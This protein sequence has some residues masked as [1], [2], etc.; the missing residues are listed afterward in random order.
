MNTP[1]RAGSWTCWLSLAALLGYAGLI[2][3][4]LGPA[5]PGAGGEWYTPTGFLYG[6]ET[7]QGTLESPPAAMG[8]AALPAAVL[9]AVVFAT[10]RSAIA[11]ALALSALVA[12][13]LFTF[14]GAQASF[15]WLFFKWR[16]SLVMIG[17]ALWVGCA[18]AAPFLAASWLRRGWPLRVALF[19]PVLFAALALMRNATGTDPD[20]P[21]MISPWPAIPVFGIVC[22]LSS[23]AVDRSP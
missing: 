14:Y 4:G 23:R 11:R 6:W 3:H 5:P 10:G 15:V 19:L 2:H 22:S 9:V 12:T 1:G 16:G 21:F 20:L 18:A 8:L 13:V 17:T 7:L